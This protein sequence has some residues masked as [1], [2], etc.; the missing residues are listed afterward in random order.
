MGLLCKA[1]EAKSGVD[2]SDY[3]LVLLCNDSSMYD[4]D[5]FSRSFDD[6]LVLTHRQ[7]SRCMTFNPD[8]SSD[9][10]SPSTFCDIEL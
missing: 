1:N 5:E 4:L 2:S 6:L 8:I 10:N 7:S 3:L 9:G